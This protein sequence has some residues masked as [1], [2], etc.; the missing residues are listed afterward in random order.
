[1]KYK[2]ILIILTGLCGI[3]ATYESYLYYTEPRAVE[4]LPVRFS[5]RAVIVP[6][7]YPEPIRVTYNTPV[8]LKGLSIFIAPH[9]KALVP[10]IR[11]VYLGTQ[12]DMQFNT[13]YH[14]VV[15]NN[16]KALEVG[17]TYTVSIR[18]KYKSILRRLIEQA[19]VVTF[20]ASPSVSGE[21]ESG[22][23]IDSRLQESQEG[24]RYKL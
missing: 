5:E 16:T 17:T 20:T 9:T 7:D 1:M 6:A 10:Q 4:V 22:V 15:L 8:S 13:Q 12:P 11:L 23:E 2:L 19:V 3:F 21:I 24:S 18:Y 14:A